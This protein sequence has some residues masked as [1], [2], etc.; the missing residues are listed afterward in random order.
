[1]TLSVIIVAYKSARQ[2]PANIVA[3]QEAL[4]EVDGGGEV[5]VVDN[6]SGD[7]AVDW[8]IREA[9]WVRVVANHENRG[10]AAACNQGVRMAKGEWLLFLNP[11]MIVPA[12]TLHGALSSAMIRSQAGALTVQLRREDQSLLPTIRRDPTVLDQLLLFLK[13]PH[14]FP[15]LQVIARYRGE[16]I[17]VGVSQRV[18]QCRASF[19]LMRRRVLDAV[20]GWDERFFLW[21][22]DVDLCRRLRGAGYS[23]WYEAS[24][25][26][27][28][29]LGRS[30]VQ[31]PLLRKQWWFFTSAAKYFW[32][33]GVRA[34]NDAS[35]FV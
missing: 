19:F 33:W 4:K 20:G 11:D 15:R 23:I 18:A 14:V 29:L 2:L 21:F 22:E 35:D 12:G 7:G 8:L 10:F 16:G 28:D 6:G 17:D 26:A 25:F 9:P 31:V 3:L 32:K 27:T 30:A 24:V 5:I 13:V 1:M 34:A